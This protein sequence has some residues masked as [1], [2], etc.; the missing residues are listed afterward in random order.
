MNLTSMCRISSFDI[1]FIVECNKTSFPQVVGPSH[2][3]K[4]EAA[5]LSF[6][7]CFMKKAL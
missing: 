5:G 3:H 6:Q 2:T 1:R 4:A 7:L